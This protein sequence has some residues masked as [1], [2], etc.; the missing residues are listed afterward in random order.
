M[1]LYA[2]TDIPSLLPQS[3]VLD[4]AARILRCLAKLPVPAR[5]RLRRDRVEGASTMRYGFQ[6]EG[7]D[8]ARG[9]ARTCV[10]EQ[11][12]E[13]LLVGWSRQCLTIEFIGEVMEEPEGQ[14]CLLGYW[15]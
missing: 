10:H 1:Y 2:P 14:T 3:Y 7:G 6:G 8:Y 12:G 4:M 9:I 13:R 11:D 5:K 15:L